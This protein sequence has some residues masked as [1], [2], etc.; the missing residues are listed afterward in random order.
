M[1]RCWQLSHEIV[2]AGLCASSAAKTMC[3]QGI[4]WSTV[5]KK[6]ETNT[7][8]SCR[9][10]LSAH[11]HARSHAHL[12]CS[13]FCIWNTMCHLAN[14]CTFTHPQ[15]CERSHTHSDMYAQTVSIPLLFFVLLVVYYR[16]QL[17]NCVGVA[18]FLHL[19]FFSCCFLKMFEIEHILN[20]LYSING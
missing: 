18:Y 16:S 10:V 15:M 8:K 17:C 1:H 6:T 13:I 20:L 3:Y 11:K 9:C 19:T 14:R 12:H 7:S 4:L 5:C 2:I